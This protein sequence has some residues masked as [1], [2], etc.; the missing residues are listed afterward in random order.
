MNEREAKQTQKHIRGFG[1]KK[2]KIVK[3]GE[4]S[5]RDENSFGV[6]IWGDKK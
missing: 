3:D 1:Y 2:V 4:K 6:V 5:L